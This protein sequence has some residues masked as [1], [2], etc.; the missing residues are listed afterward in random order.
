MSMQ[1]NATD[2]PLCAADF[3]L[4]KYLCDSKN[5]KATVKPYFRV[6]VVDEA[7]KRA[8]SRAYFLDELN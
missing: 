5:D 6:T 4:N 7:G 1:K 2:A 8:Y 3:D